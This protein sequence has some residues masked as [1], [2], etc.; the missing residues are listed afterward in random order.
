MRAIFA[1]VLL[2]CATPA[3]ADETIGSLATFDPVTN[4]L[5]LTDKTVWMLPKDTA[6]PENMAPGERLRIVYKS[7][8]DNGWVTIVKIERAAS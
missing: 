2:A 1:A 7:Q 8:S 4:W 5:T 3:L 6:L